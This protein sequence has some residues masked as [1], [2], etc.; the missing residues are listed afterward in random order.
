MKKFCLYINLPVLIFLLNF[1]LAAQTFAELDE[2]YGPSADGV[3]KVGE[4]ISFKVKYGEDEKICLATI[5]KRFTFEEERPV[6][7]LNNEKPPDESPEKKI[8]NELMKTLFPDSLFGKLIKDK[9]GQT[10]NCFSTNQVEYENAVISGYTQ[11]CLGNANYRST[12]TVFW[13]RDACRKL[14]ETGAITTIKIP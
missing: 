13:K 1:S 4:K 7:V 2:K 3:Y 9:G 14:K 6:F 5:S 11:V 10:G 8:Y 12:T